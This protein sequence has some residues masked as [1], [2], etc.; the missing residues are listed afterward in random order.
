MSP[1][2]KTMVQEALKPIVSSRSGKISSKEAECVKLVGEKRYRELKNLFE[3]GKINPATVPKDAK[4]SAEEKKT[5]Y[6][7]EE[8]TELGQQ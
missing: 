8:I 1:T 3:S 7:I 4:Y 6:Y 2:K 5:L